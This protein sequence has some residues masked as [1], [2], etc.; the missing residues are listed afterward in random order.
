MNCDNS[1]AKTILAID[2]GKYK[3][4]ACSFAGDPGKAEF[5]SLVTDRQR[6]GKLIQ[7][8]K[9]SVVLAGHLRLAGLAGAECTHEAPDTARHRTPRVCMP[10]KASVCLRVPGLREYTQPRPTEGCPSGTRGH[11]QIHKS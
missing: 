9:A 4:V 10:T 8:A 7:Q 6:L 11:L 2:L 1:I 5:V 3:S